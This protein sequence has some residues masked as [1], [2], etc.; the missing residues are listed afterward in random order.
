MSRKAYERKDENLKDNPNYVRNSSL[1]DT[2]D[3]AVTGIINS[4]RSERNMKIHLAAAIFILMISIILKVSRLELAIL[5]I[6]IMLVF[7]AEIFNTAIEELTD[8]VTRSRYS[9]G[10]KKAKDISAGAVFLTAINATFVGYIILY[11]RLKFLVQTGEI[12]IRAI[13]ESRANVTIITIGLILILV[14][15]L[16]AFFYKKHTTHFQGGTVSGHS[17]LAFCLATIGTMITKN[18]GAT[19]LFYGLALL[20]A[21]ARVE[22]RI[23]TCLEVF[24]GAI[25]GGSVSFIIFKLFF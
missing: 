4:V 24:L 21:E 1:I 16:K 23:H 6:C 2:F 19:I 7:V 20:V 8:M 12:G 22:T 5:T 10:A 13:F 9:K 25:L 17:A 11:P 3:N 18:L 14:L 15:V